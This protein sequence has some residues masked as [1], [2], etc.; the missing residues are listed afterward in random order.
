[1]T[2]TYSLKD[3]HVTVAGPTGSVI[4]GGGLGGVAEGGIKIEPA[5]DKNI[6]TVGAD[7]SVMHSLVA[8][9]ASTVTITLLKTA[10][11]NT[12]LMAMYNV[13]TQTGLLHGK[14]TIAINDFRGDAIANLSAAFKKRPTFTYDKEGGTMEWTF[15]A[16]LTVPVLGTGVPGA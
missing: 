5:N 4:L 14:N 16:A 1:M 7:G 9:E 10:V 11:A 13:Q 15:D 12:I 6:M 8:G 3:V 2:G